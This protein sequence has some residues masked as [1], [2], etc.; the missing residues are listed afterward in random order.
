MVTR[1]TQCLK[2]RLPVFNFI[3]E[4]HYLALLE[5]ANWPLIRKYGEKTL[6]T[7]AHHQSLPTLKAPML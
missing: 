4:L 6:F 1:F 5:F 3:G 2:E 7:V